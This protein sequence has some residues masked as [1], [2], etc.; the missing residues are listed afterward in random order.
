MKP[1][2]VSMLLVVPELSRAGFDPSQ[3][4][5]RHYYERA[6]AAGRPVRGLETAAY[7]VERLN[8]LPLPV[9]VEMLKATLDDV[10]AQVESVET[11]VTAWRSGDL[12]TLDKLLLQSFRETPAIY[13]R[14]LVDRNRN[15]VPLIASVPPNRRPAWSWSAAP[16]CSAPTGW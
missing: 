11:I 3:G 2:L 9:Q 10:E 12:A 8:G 4:L 1:W 14:L 13:Q 7:Q 6:R 5:D 15:W 16:T